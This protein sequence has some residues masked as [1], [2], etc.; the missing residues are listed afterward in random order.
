MEK[1]ISEA[2]AKALDLLEQIE[3]V[4][5][6]IQTHA[7]DSFMQ[8]QYQHRKQEFVQK[9]VETLKEFDIQPKDLAA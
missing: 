8:N 9:L 1:I 2:A 4:N 5:Q 6:M 7:G 3:S